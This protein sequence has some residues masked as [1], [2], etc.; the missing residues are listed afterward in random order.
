M[1]ILVVTPHTDDFIYGVGGTLI[2]HA[3]DDIH[4]VAVSSIQQSAARDVAAAFG[5]TIEFLDAPYHRISDHAQRVKDALAAILRE[6]RPA[7][8]F[9]PPATGDWTSDHTTVGRVLLDATDLAGTFAYKSRVLRFPIAST[10]LDFHPNVW[11]DLPVEIAQRKIELAAVMTRGLEDEW[12]K[13]LVEWEVNL[14]LRYALDIGWP[15]R[16]AEAFDAVFACPSTG[17]R[18][19]RNSRASRSG[20]AKGRRARRGVDLSAGPSAGRPGAGRMSPVGMGLI[21]TGYM[22]RT[23]A[24]CLTRHVPNGRW[25]R[26]GAASARRRWPRSSAS[27]PTSLEALLA[28]P[29][30]EAVVITSP[31]RRTGHRPRPRRQPAS[32]STSRSRCRSRSPTATRSSRP[33][34]RAASSSRSTS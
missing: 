22:G 3:D 7:Y 32:T 5:A 34:T 33:A 9:G 14:G 12:P 23:Y 8:V 15:S 16:H 27:R 26:S 6:R 13:D 31:T 1:E 24:A 25:S 19:G 17:C 18:R 2:T 20:W 11:I 4:I 29:D 10:T 21:G 30:V 28:R